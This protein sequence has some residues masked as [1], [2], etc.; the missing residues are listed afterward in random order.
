MQT[1]DFEIEEKKLQLAN[2][3]K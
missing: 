1:K 3:K 2:I